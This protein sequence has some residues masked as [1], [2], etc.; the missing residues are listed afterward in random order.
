[1]TPAEQFTAAN[2]DRFLAELFD[3]LRIPSISAKSEHN[4][5]TR[6]AAGWLRDRMRDIGLEAEILE[7]PR[8][9][10]VLGEWRGA[11][12]DAPTVLV[13]GHYDVQPAEPLELWT[14]PA[15]EP[16][17]RDG[18]IY[19]RGSADDK[20]QLFLHVKA[21]E[22]LLAA[23]G[24]LPV[25]LIVLAEG[26][27]EI[28]SPNLIPFV[29]A[30]AERLAC[31]VVVISDSAMFAPGL[32]S[33]LFSLRGLAYFEITVHGPASDLH[34][35]SYG[36]GV[37]NPAMALARILGTLHDENG[38]IAIPGFYDDVVDWGDETRAEIRA[39]PFDD[40]EFRDG[41]GVAALSGEAGYSTLERLWIRPT[42]EVNGL[43]SGYTGEG[44]KTVL[45]AHSMAKVSFRLVPDQDPAR[46]AKLLRAHIARVA[47]PEVRVEIEELH[48]GMPWR[49]Q[50]SGGLI[51]A[52]SRALARS[53]GRRPV[54]TGEGG[55]IPIVGEFER[56][57]E[58]PVLLLGFAL[59]GA[60]MHAPDE[61]FP[62]ENFDKGIVALAAL[63]EE[64]GSGAFAA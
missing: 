16:D 61:W 3:F 56:I 47:P 43:L 4:G 11:G 20:G 9:P 48:G 6:H 38:R 26:E 21:A 57:L 50:V 54:L 1:M 15:F 51:D 52:A 44:A 63:L 23:D 27:E 2:L 40:E 60:N 25:N 29:E 46:V 33:V 19:A 14:A 31:D 39:L 22:S 53:F 64:L 18:R 17:V 24:R 34:S 45:P 35:G 28:G 62:L 12:D 49:G 55:S 36:G 7:T 41:V 42:C 8:H 58:A 10:V 13:Y 5:D 37:V 32:P 59:P 30:H